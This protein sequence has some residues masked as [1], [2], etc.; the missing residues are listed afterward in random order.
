MTVT[1]C[2]RWNS[3]FASSAP[4]RPQPTTMTCM[5][6]SNQPRLRQAGGDVDVL[7][8]RAASDRDMDALRPCCTPYHAVGTATGGALHGGEIGGEVIL[9]Q[10]G[11]NP[12]FLPHVAFAQPG[13]IQRSGVVDAEKQERAVATAVHGGHVAGDLA[14]DF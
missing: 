2:P 6:T 8:P 11:Q 13:F 9:R 7:R 12:E 14:Q 10:S 3:R 4:K 5:L 1:S